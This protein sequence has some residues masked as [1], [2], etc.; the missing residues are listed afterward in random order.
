[1]RFWRSRCSTTAR[2]SPTGGWD[3]LT[4]SVSE[5]LFRVSVL[6]LHSEDGGGTCGPRIGSATTADQ[7]LCLGPFWIPNAAMQ[8]MKTVSS[9][10]S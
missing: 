9:Y 4:K 7:V 10:Q 6:R 8:I 5:L 2:C 1:M 3:H